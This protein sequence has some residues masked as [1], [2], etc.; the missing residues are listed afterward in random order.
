MHNGLSAALSTDPK[1]VERQTGG[2]L[3][4]LGVTPIMTS[5][6][7]DRNAKVG[8]HNYHQGRR[9]TKNPRNVPLGMS[10]RDIHPNHKKIPN[11][12]LANVLN[13]GTSNRPARPWLSN[14]R[15]KARRTAVPEM[16]RV[17]AEELA[18]L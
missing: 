16:E 18:K 6:N 2:L 12:M 3:D 9:K 4:A 11:Q 5:R 10:N 1:D 17:L 7:G 14:A 8:F 13:S 15:A